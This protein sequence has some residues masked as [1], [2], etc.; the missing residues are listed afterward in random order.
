MGQI[1]FTWQIIVLCV[2]YDLMQSFLLLKRLINGDFFIA[3]LTS[4]VDSYRDIMPSYLKLKCCGKMLV[5]FFV[6]DIL[7][8]L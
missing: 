2:I 3:G 1:F 4:K 8:F 6:L 5:F 7:L